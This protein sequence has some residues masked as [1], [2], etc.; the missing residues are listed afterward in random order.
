MDLSAWGNLASIVGLPLAILA[1]IGLGKELWAKLMTKKMWL[2]NTLMGIV[3]L[4]WIIQLLA[5]FGVLKPTPSVYAPIPVIGKTFVNERVPLDGY[6]YDK[7]TFRNVT[8]DYNGTT[9]VQLAG[10][11]VEGSI[12]IRSNSLAVA[13][14]VS[15]MKGMGYLRSDMNMSFVNPNNFVEAPKQQ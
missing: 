12:G 3:A 10:N 9:P 6:R 8:F 7:C 5:F 4:L 14:T 15:L 13:G 1:Y 11:N 2:P